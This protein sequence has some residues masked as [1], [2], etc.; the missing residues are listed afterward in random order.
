MKYEVVYTKQAETE[1]LKRERDFWLKRAE[2]LQMKLEGIY[3]D[4]ERNGRVALRHRGKIMNLTVLLEPAPSL[5][6]GD[7]Q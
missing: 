5:P 7:N 4:A 3:D 1:L 6:N 2:E